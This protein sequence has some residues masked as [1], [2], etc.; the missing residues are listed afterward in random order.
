[1]AYSIILLLNGKDEKHVFLCG[2]HNR[3]Y[4]CLVGRSEFKRSLERVVVVC[5]VIS[6][7]TNKMNGV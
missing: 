3:N 2:M 7:M 5:W 6:I 4:H 1:M